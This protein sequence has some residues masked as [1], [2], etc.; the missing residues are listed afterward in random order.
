MRSAYSKFE[1]VA[2]VALPL[3]L[4]MSVALAASDAGDAKPSAAAKTYVWLF[5]PA[6]CE[7]SLLQRFDLGDSVC[8]KL[9]LVRVLNI[10]ITSLAWV[11]KAPQA[12][13]IMK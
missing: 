2:A 3:A 11:L 13:K 10:A 6:Q 5:V 9:L 12:I 4:V 7:A 1:N 8:L